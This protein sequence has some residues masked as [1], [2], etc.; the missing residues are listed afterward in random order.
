MMRLWPSSLIGRTVVVLL[1]GLVLSNLIGFGFY[2]HDR[3][4]SL[5]AARANY[6]ADRIV[7]LTSSVEE[8]APAVRP[9]FVRRLRGPGFRVAF[10]PVDSLAPTGLIVGPWQ[11]TI[12]EA[13]IDEWG[14]DPGDR[15]RIGVV[16]PEKI[17]RLIEE[18]VQRDRNDR[19]NQ[20]MMDQN[21]PRQ[22]MRGRGYRGGQGRNRGSA[23]DDYPPPPEYGEEILAVSFQLSGGGWMNFLMLMP[24]SDLKPFWATGIFLPVLLA[25]LAVIAISV[26]AVW[27]AIAPLALFTRAAE[28]LGRDV[29]APPLEERGPREVS[30]AARAFN[31]MQKRLRS[32]IEDRTQMLAAISHDLRT[33]ITRMRLRAEFVEDE[34]QRD[35]M[36]K[37]LDEMEAMIAATLSFARD[38]ATREQRVQIDLADL[39]QSLCDQAADGGAAADYAGPRRLAMFGAPMALKRAFSNLIDNALKY[40]NAVHVALEEG[41][42]EVVVTVADEGPGI[43]ENQ[44]EKVFAAFYRVEGSRSR[45]TGGVGLGL[46][47]V[48]SILRGH[49]GDIA[50][51]NRPEGGLQATVTLPRD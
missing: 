20:H 4:H 3:A 46:A 35:K 36:L 14:S 51:S 41:E 19:R 10:T 12:R 49:G 1:L 38:D 2:W 33:P 16:P 25:T 28:R 43:P 42:G 31:G 9:E 8:V 29:T 37:D 44:L 47:V 13:V 22:G 6:L 11:R 15:L 50:L 34:E 32:F 26:F 18:F 27:R 39:L 24:Q 23:P 45:E 17:N 40:G 7:S 48:R 21:S 30:H 5:A